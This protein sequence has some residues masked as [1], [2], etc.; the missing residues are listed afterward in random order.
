MDIP[1]VISFNDH[2]TIPAGVCLSSLCT[3]AIAD[4]KYTVYVLFAQQRLAKEN[5]ARIAEL[6]HYF[7]N[8]SLNFIDVADAFNGSY[9]VRNVTIESYYRLLIPKLISDFDKVIYI[10][11]DTIINDDLTVLY[12]T[13]LNSYPIAG[14]PEFYANAE[15]TQSSYIRSL[16]LSPQNYINAGILLFN[17]KAIREQQHFNDSTIGKLTNLNLLYQDQDIINI[18]FKDYIMPL[19]HIFNYTYSKLKEGLIIRNPAIIHYTLEKPWKC[20]RPFGEIWWEH[21]KNSIFYDDEY[22]INY[23]LKAF[24]HINTHIKVGKMIKRIGLYKLIDF[25]KL[26]YNI[27][28][29]FYTKLSLPKQY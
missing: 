16:H 22:Y 28:K 1:I 4:T 29:S 12:N 18:L 19:D 11:V 5:R 27:F 21:Y 13:E 25:K 9:E 6:E 8:L 10:D 15:L 14:V 26:L 3:N 2:F 23:Q 24:D 20:S 17:L 7:N